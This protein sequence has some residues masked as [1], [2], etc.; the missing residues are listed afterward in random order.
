VENRHLAL[1][2]ADGGAYEDP[3]DSRHRFGNGVTPLR[4]GRITRRRRPVALRRRV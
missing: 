3:D 2:C 1:F 4:L